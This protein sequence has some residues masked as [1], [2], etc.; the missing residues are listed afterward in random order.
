MSIQDI[1]DIT[2]TMN[3]KSIMHMDRL[4]VGNLN[5]E[6]NTDYDASTDLLASMIKCYR[7]DTIGTQAEGLSLA[8]SVIDYFSELDTV[9][10]IEPTEAIEVIQ[11]FL[12]YVRGE[13]E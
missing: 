7:E 10:D 3:G 2:V 13:I 8:F 5:W 12:D 9:W 4:I 11:D 6:A 1:K